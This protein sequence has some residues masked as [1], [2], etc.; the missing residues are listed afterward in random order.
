MG[1]RRFGQTFVSIMLVAE[2]TLS[3]RHLIT[4]CCGKEEREKAGEHPPPTEE[5]KEAVAAINI[6]IWLP[7]AISAYSL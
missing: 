2:L 5:L 3:P 1:C 6:S 7:V 4:S